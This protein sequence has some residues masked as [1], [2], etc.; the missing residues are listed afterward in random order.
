[1][2]YEDILTKLTSKSFF[3]QF[4][5]LYRMKKTMEHFGNPEERLR[6][7]H[8]AGTNGK[9]SVS[10][11]LHAVLKEAGYRVGLFTSPFIHDFRERIQ[12]NGEMI[13][14]EALTEI[15]AEVMNYTDT[16]S[17]APNQFE[18]LTI[19][20]L[21][22][23]EREKCDIVVLETGLGGTYDPTNIVPAPLCS[24]IMNIGLDHC[25]ILGNTIAEI[26]AAKA[27][28]IKKDCDVVL[29]PSCAEAV[30]VLEKTAESKNAP[31]HTIDLALIKP[32]PK[33]D[34]FEHFRYR[35]YDI[36]LKLLGRHQQKNCAVAI[37]TIMVLNKMDFYIS[38]IDIIR[39]MANVEWPARM[40]LMH[41]RPTV[42]L[43]GGHN[44]QCISAAEEFFSNS[45]FV[46]RKIHV[47][48][49]ILADKDY[50]SML[51]IMDEFAD[52]ITFFRFDHPR[53]IPEETLAELCEEFDLKRTDSP[54]EWIAKYLKKGSDK[55]VILCI[56]SLYMTDRIRTFFGKNKKE[57]D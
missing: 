10:A 35:D 45:A 3:S 48:T 15:A 6:V 28:I 44:P 30:E 32:L 41:M 34:G 50:R 24:V 54:E 46:G 12:I 23:F 8:V 29:Y 14:K 4:A 55:D 38:D 18:L 49:G 13:S 1:M 31:V 22:Y 21:L 56:G 51:T 20:A 25:A 5:G 47:L 33:I 43:D 42:Y 7:I 17:D 19:I 39:G 11:M 40:E 37:E 9:G 26:A 2:N 36:E 27:G 53:S 52:D 57:E 16:L